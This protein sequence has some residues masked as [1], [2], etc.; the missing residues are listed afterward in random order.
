MQAPAENVQETVLFATALAKR[1]ASA[2]DG[3][4]MDTC[5]Y[6][7]FGPSGWPVENPVPDF[8]AREHV[9]VHVETGGGADARWVHTHGLIKF[10]RPEMEIY[11]VP[12]EMDGVAYTMLL[13]IAQYTIT[14]ALIAPG[15]TCGDPKQPFFVCEGKKNRRGHWEA[16]PVLELVDLAENGKPVS[17]GAAKAL[18]AFAALPEQ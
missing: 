14:S 18:Q 13:D 12:P 8:D 5:A 4:V 6:R 7:F 17:S 2:S 15:Q 9:H 11:E 3:V 1:L 16:V 10:G